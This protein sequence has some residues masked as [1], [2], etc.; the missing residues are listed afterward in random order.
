M[1]LGFVSEFRFGSIGSPV[2]GNR[3]AAMPLGKQNPGAAFC[4]DM[5]TQMR[6]FTRGLFLRGNARITLQLWLD[7]VIPLGQSFVAL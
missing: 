6:E 4:R 7:G 2:S 5:L 3:G 1:V